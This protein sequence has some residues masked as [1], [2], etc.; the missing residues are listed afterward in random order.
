MGRSIGIIKVLMLALAVLCTGACTQR[1]MKQKM[2]ELDRELD[3]KSIHMERFNARMDSLR[4]SL[5]TKNMPDS[6]RW[7]IAYSLFSSYSYVNLDSTLRY[8]SVLE[9]YATDSELLN[10]TKACRIRSYGLEQDNASLAASIEEIDPDSVSKGFRQRYFDELQR[11]YV[12]LPGNTTLKKNILRSALEFEDLSLDV[13]SRYEG[14]LLLYDERYAE[15]LPLFEKSFRTASRDHIKALASYNMA[16]CHKQLGDNTRYRQCLAQSA[17]YDIRVPVSEYLSLLELSE[18]LFEK[19]DYT[20]ASRY[21]RVVMEDAIEGNWESRIQLSASSQNAIFSALD[22]SHSQ[23]IRL[24]MEFIIFLTLFVLIVLGLLLIMSRQNRNLRA[25]NE[26]VIE[27]N[28]KLEDEGRI[29]ESYLF[30]YMEMSVEGIGRLEDYHHKVHQVLKEEGPEA[31]LSMLRAPRSRSDYKAFYANFDKTF[32][33]LYPEFIK[34][35]N[36]L[37]KDDHEFKDEGVL[38][39]DLRILATIRLGFNDSGQIARFLNIPA[40]SV[41]TRRSALRRN[42]I[43]PKDDLDDLIRQIT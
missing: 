32:L 21:I 41:Y 38:T 24:M 31:L 11:A 7:E 23:V 33:S 28:S 3:C 2:L 16:T 40:T 6:L 34:Q 26:K 20:M 39:T 30:K 12:Q 22:K 17:I 4:T 10:R 14:L 37:M 43:C 29:K 9:S 42:S 27:I 13:R 8:L 15:A 5:E 25:L 36:T 18:S 19:G 35:V 1:D